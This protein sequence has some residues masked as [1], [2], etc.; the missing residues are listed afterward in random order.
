MPAT[1]MTMR[2]HKTLENRLRRKAKAM[3][4][5]LRRSRTRDRWADDYGLYVLVDDCRGNRFPG[6]RAPYAAFERGE[7]KSLIGIAEELRQLE[8][9]GRY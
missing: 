7:G 6:A 5:L 1:T 8:H 2:E 9:L 3:G 4:F